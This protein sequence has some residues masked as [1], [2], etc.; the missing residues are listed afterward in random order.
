MGSLR[1]LTNKLK[2]LK[3]LL[4]ERDGLNLCRLHLV[5]T[6][7]VSD[8]QEGGLHLSLLYLPSDG[9][10]LAV[11]RDE[12]VEIRYVNYLTSVSYLWCK[13]VHVDFCRSVE[14]EFEVVESV[15]QGKI[16][17]NFVPSPFCN[18]FYKETNDL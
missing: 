11:L 7:P 1:R 15:C 3:I 4:V 18:P 16:R 13:F 8:S 5:V 17:G 10:L 12:V 6:C 2:A 9:T 14:E